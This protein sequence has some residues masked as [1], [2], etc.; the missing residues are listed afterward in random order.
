M[1][2]DRMSAPDGKVPAAPAPDY[3]VAHTF[4]RENAMRITMSRHRLKP[5]E[6]S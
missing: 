2:V 3:F 4:L 5:R 6:E 1:I